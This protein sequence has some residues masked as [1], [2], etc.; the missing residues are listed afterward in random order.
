MKVSG[1]VSLDEILAA[2]SA[3]RSHS[4]GTPL[5]RLRGTE[6]WL[7]AESLQPT[8]S[9]K[10]R[11]AIYKISVLNDNERARG[12]V[13][14]SSGNHAQAV[15]FA[16]RMFHTSATIVMPSNASVSKVEATRYYGADIVFA[17][18]ST[19]VLEAVALDLEK[20]KGYLPV[21]PFNDRAIIAATGTVALELVEQLPDVTAITVPISG[22]GLIAGIAT[23]IKSTRPD[24]RIIGVEPE[25]A[26]DAYESFKAGKRVKFA[27]EQMNRTIAD[28]LRVCCVGDLTWEHIRA[29]VDEVVTVTEAEI[30]GAMRQVATKARLVAE[31]S[32]AV[33]VAAWLTGRLMSRGSVAAILSGGNVDASVLSLALAAGKS[34]PPNPLSG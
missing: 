24:I 20:S 26:A 30:L 8:G 12:V 18:G 6:V 7:K 10:L 13:A 32:G 34:T 4:L 15:A 11:G 2:R 19:D 27:A 16:A 29:Y 21:P 28:G 1:L 25:V 3:L 17:T 23:A 5:V 14:S 33:S 9:F 31:P 22:G